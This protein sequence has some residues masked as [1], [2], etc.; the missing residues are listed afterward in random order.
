MKKLILLTPL[1]F[2]MFN[3]CQPSENQKYDDALRFNVPFSQ[4]IPSYQSKNFDVTH[5]EAFTIQ[6]GNTESIQA[7]TPAG[8]FYAQNMLAMNEN[9]RSVRQEKTFQTSPFY[10]YR[11]MHIDVSRHYFSV[12]AIERFIQQIAVLRFNKLQIHL[13]DDQGWRIE[14]PQYPALTDTGAYRYDTDTATERYGNFYTQKELKH[15]VKFAQKY[16]IEIIPEVDFPAHSRS[17]LA[18]MPNLSCSGKPEVVGRMVNN[19]PGCSTLCI[20]NPETWKYAE[21]VL[22]NLCEIFPSEY[23]HIGG[24]EC[25]P[26]PWRTCPKCQKLAKEHQLKNTDEVFGIFMNHLI[27]YL[28]KKGRTAIVWDEYMSSPLPL[29]E[30]RPVVMVWQ[31]AQRYFEIKD[32]GCQMIMAPANHLYFDYRQEDIYQPNAFGDHTLRL[33]DVYKLPI[34]NDSNIIGINACLW[35]E[36]IAT[37]AQ[38]NYMA[39]PRILAVAEK[40]WN[41]PYALSWYTFKKCVAPYLKGW[42]KAKINACTAGFDVQFSADYPL[43]PNVV[44]VF[45]N[46]E[47]DVNPKNE[48][49]ILYTF[50]SENGTSQKVQTASNMRASFTESG[51]IHAYINTFPPTERRTHCQI[52]LHKGI[53]RLVAEQATKQH[54]NYFGHV[55]IETLC[56]GIIATSD[57]RDKNWVG[58]EKNDSEPVELV[59]AY[60]QEETIDTVALHVLH[61]HNSWIVYPSKIELFAD[62]QTTPFH[63]QSWANDTQLDLEITTTLRSVTFPKQKLQKL[64]IKVYPGLLPNGHYRAGLPGWI[65]CSEVIVK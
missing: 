6:T 65:F 36:N 20:G 53:A 55:G 8:K 42:E 60:P 50:K 34:H 64:T 22:D 33:E 54:P 61:K 23:I 41:G 24:D 28:A 58:W 30:K 7:H 5:P 52:E 18:S 26:S 25:D 27:D 21:V 57:Y 47:L 3:A 13:T 62:S 49:E 31:S 17:V 10:N 56:D 29:P 4:M 46:A 14:I 51:M 44:K 63:T 45:M 35:A 2:L 48:N 16:Q 59:Y 32:S 12:D 15:L 43:T 9:L 38:L 11:S 19:P 39:F 40:A 37:E 1:L